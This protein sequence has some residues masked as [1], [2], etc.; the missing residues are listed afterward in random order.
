VCDLE[1]SKRGGLCPISVVATQW[2]YLQIPTETSCSRGK[3][4]SPISALYGNCSFTAES[5]DPTVN[6]CM[7]LINPNP[8]IP[9]FR[10]VYSA[11]NWSLPN[12]NIF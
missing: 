5:Q 1:I 6:P 7:S 4:F 3:K 9:S 12:G 8:T 2:K 10:Y 11:N